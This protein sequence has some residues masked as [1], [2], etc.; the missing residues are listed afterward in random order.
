MPKFTEPVSQSVVSPTADP[1]VMS[2]ILALSH[3]FFEIDIM[4]YFFQKLR[5]MMQ[6]L[7]SAAVTIGASRVNL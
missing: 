7:L 2:S 1:G 6:N 5:K 4:P 3:A